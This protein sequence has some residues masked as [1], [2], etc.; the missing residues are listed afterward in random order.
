MKLGDIFTPVK[1]NFLINKEGD[2]LKSKITFGLEIELEN[3]S[4]HFNNP[5]WMCCAD[6]SL[7]EGLEYKFSQPLWGKDVEV[8]LQDFQSWISVYHPVVSDR[9]STHIHVGAEHFKD[10]D[11]LHRFLVVY[12]SLERVLYNSL[13]P[14]RLNNIYCLPL[15]K[16]KETFSK[17]SQVKNDSPAWVIK[18]ALYTEKYISVNTGSLNRLGTIEFRMFHG[19]HDTSEI[20]TWFKY[21]IRLIEYSETLEDVSN[22]PEMVSTSGMIKWVKDVLGDEL[23]NK[24]KYDEMEGDIIKGVRA[25]QL[26]IH[27]ETLS[28][29]SGRYEVCDVAIKS[30]PFDSLKVGGE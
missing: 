2:T 20:M 17:L 13:H 12:L 1:S 23:F 29:S 26:V 4:A 5:R 11:H 21:L 14:A 9:C 7:R 19:T 3:I 18:D 8:A 30:T 15:F 6:G 28:Y 25:A 24:L 27:Y 10:I 22:F 16:L